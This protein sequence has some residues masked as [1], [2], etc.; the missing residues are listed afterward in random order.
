VNG[1]DY[2]ID[3][4][5]VT[6]LGPGGHSAMSDD[7]S[8]PHGLPGTPG[9][10]AAT[11][12]DGSATVSWTAADWNGGWGDYEV[13]ASPGGAT[14]RTS[15]L[16]AQ[17]PG[18][19]AGT[20]YT[21]AVRALSVTG[22][23][24][25]ATSAPVTPFGVPTAPA[26][27]T[28][29]PKNAAAH[30][31]WTAAEPNGSPV[32][33]YTVTASPGGATTTVAG[34]TLAAD[35]GGLA[36]G[37][38]YTVTVT[39]ANAAGDGPASAP[40]ASVTPDSTAPTVTLRVVAPVTL[41]GSVPLSYAATDAGGSG[42]ASTV[43][44][45]RAAPYGGPFGAFH[46]LGTVTAAPVSRGYT[47][48]FSVAAADV[49]GNVAP[50]SAERCTVTPLDDRALSASP[51]WQ[52]GTGAS[53][54]AGTFTA[55]VVKGATLTRTGVSGRRLVL[56]YATIPDGATLGVYLDGVL[57]KQVPTASAATAYRR[58]TTIDFGAVKSGTITVRTLTGGRAYVDGLGVSRV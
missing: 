51:S 37:T 12:G 21:F 32:D 15:S 34:D 57:L 43:V 19:A 7:R 29:T 9:D 26:A 38:A 55:T 39:A 41:S 46:A 58:V 56:V 24:P 8:T 1:K 30:V 27:M 6:E 36:N 50:W 52:R 25:V 35:L 3:V 20:A 17:V 11:A 13:V 54:Y 44:R 2:R 22:S 45:Y 48:C 42:V 5:V 40:S 47:Y 14:V 18:L 28:A 31:A 4:Q 53:H 49:A 10:V 16:S 33:H 23:G